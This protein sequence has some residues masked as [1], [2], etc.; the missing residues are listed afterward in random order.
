MPVAICLELRLGPVPILEV[1]R[2]S[3]FVRQ[4]SQRSKRSV[5]ARFRLAGTAKRAVGLEKWLAT[6]LD[7][8]IEI[9]CS[10]GTNR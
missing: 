6:V 7:G 8:S 2:F 4:R 3:G 10:G 1:G 9:A 5:D